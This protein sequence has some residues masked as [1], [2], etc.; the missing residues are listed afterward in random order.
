[1]AQDTPTGA[2]DIPAGSER[3]KQACGA[4]P[5][6]QRPYKLRLAATTPKHDNPNRS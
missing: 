1:M 5:F 4:N 6:P 2:P 3:V